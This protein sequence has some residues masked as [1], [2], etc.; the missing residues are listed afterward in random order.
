M[1][2][3]CESF[4]D[5]RDSLPVA[6][7]VAGNVNGGSICVSFAIGLR[8][9]GALSA[10]LFE[11][12][13]RRDGCFG[14]FQPS[15]DC[16]DELR[17]KFGCAN[18]ISSSSFEILS[19]ILSFV[20]VLLSHSKPSFLLLFFLFVVRFFFWERIL[21]KTKKETQQNKICKK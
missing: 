1:Y 3:C 7:P 16:N 4:R 12:V 11:F 2:E 13:L 15:N 19:S 14:I 9:V 8:G 5:T 10:V 6:V 18:I 17:F 20:F 21:T